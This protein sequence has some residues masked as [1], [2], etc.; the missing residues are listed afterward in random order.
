MFFDWEGQFFKKRIFTEG[1]IPYRLVLVSV[2]AH[3]IVRHITTC[4]KSYY[5]D[6][7]VKSYY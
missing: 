2:E 4:K 7:P 6:V 5:L 1:R 3:Q